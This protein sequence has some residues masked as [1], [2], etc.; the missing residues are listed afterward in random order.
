VGGPKWVELPAFDKVAIVAG[1]VDNGVAH[2]EAA[3]VDPGVGLLPVRDEERYMVRMDVVAQ[4]SQA[5]E[6][7]YPRVGTL[8]QL[9][10][11]RAS[12]MP[13]GLNWK[14]EQPGRSVTPGGSTKMRFSF[15]TKEEELGLKKIEIKPIGPLADHAATLGQPFPNF[16]KKGRTYVDYEA[17]TAKEAPTGYHLVSTTLFTADGAPAVIQASLRIAPLVDFVLGDD[18]IELKTGVQEIKI[19]FFIKSNTTNR[20]DGSCAVEVPA[21]WEILKGD[22]K[23]FIIYNSR[24]GVRRVLTVKI[25]ADTQGTV[26]IRFKGEI[27]KK[28]VED[29][30][31]LTI[32]RK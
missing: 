23:G 7:F 14:V 13:V 26:P 11:E 8:I 25:P 10:T 18:T 9:R 20:L 22:E 21:N 3:L 24:A 6:P 16:D 5:T 1:K 31:W 32:K 15:S 27:G 29:V 12:A 19:P 28:T 2:I 30:L 17:K 4:S